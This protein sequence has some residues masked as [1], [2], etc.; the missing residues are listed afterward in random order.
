MERALEDKKR[1][2][3]KGGEMRYLCRQEVR[4]APCPEQWNVFLSPKGNQ[5]PDI[6]E[7]TLNL[8]I[9]MSFTCWKKVPRYPSEPHSGLLCSCPILP[10]SR[11]LT[12]RQRRNPPTVGHPPSILFFWT[13][14]QRLTSSP[15]TLELKGALTIPWFLI[16]TLLMTAD[17]ILV[18]GYG[19]RGHSRVSCFAPVHECLLGSRQEV[20]PRL[21]EKYPV[22]QLCT[23]IN[24]KIT[25]FNERVW[26]GKIRIITFLK[27]GNLQIW[28]S[29]NI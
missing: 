23:E 3:W 25:H 20:G 7:E 1:Q 12:V 14:L 21:R 17:H 26:T 28:K 15:Q 18:R 16:L 8:L 27:P 4:R 6:M 13:L 29:D 11:R 2:I 24:N 19:Q 5:D 22:W 10:W 9:L